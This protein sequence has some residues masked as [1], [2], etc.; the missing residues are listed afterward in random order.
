MKT[1]ISHLRCNKMNQILNDKSF[2]TQDKKSYFHIRHQGS[3]LID[4]LKIWDKVTSE[5]RESLN[6]KVKG[7]LFT[8]KSY[9]NENRT[10]VF[11][12]SFISGEDFEKISK[13]SFCKKTKSFIVI[14][15]PNHII[16]SNG[17]K[18]YQYICPS[19]I[20]IL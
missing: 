10:N 9:W 19:L 3:M 8:L 6:V 18:G 11:Y 20:E 16:I 13:F 1:Q 2:Y 14:R 5:N 15:F 7:C 12:K 17:N 4:C